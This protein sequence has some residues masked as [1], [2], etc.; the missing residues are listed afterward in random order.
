ML[1]QIVLG[2]HKSDSYREL[3]SELL[4]S[5]QALGCNMSLKIHFLDSHLDFFP[6]NLGAASDE[7]GERFHQDIS[8]MEK[9]YQGKWSPNMLADYCWTIKRDQPEAKH[10]RK[11]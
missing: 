5:Y 9:R 7:H 10:S 4:L 11:S 3:V 8:S 6:D 2:N 1:L